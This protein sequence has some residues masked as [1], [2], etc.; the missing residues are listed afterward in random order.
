MKNKKEIALRK[1]SQ[2]AKDQVIARGDPVRP[3][4]PAE[5]IEVMYLSSPGTLNVNQNPGGLNWAG[6]KKIFKEIINY[7]ETSLD[8]IMCLLK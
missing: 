4:Y 6:E 8:W 7:V 3:N 5:M 2:S 1:K